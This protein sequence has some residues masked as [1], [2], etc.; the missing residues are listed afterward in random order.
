[1]PSTA[2]QY[3]HGSIHAVDDADL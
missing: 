3:S 1:V 2:T